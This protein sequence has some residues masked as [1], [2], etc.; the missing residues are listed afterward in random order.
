MN[1]ITV[2]RNFLIFAVMIKLKSSCRLLRI[3]SPHRRWQSKA[4]L[5]RFQIVSIKGSPPLI[6][7]DFLLHFLSRYFKRH[8]TVWVPICEGNVGSSEGRIPFDAGFPIGARASLLAHD[9][10]Q[11]SLVCYS[12][13]IPLLPD[14][15]GKGLASSSA[16]RADSGW[17]TLFSGRR[18]GGF[19]DTKVTQT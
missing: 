14:D 10:P 12:F 19:C 13:V 6:G 9:F 1:C 11:E 7:T 5:L 3:M 18:T 2:N 15:A 4:V 17:Q 8:F 16:V